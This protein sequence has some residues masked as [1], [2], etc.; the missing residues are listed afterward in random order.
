MIQLCTS[1][2]R[3]KYA[4]S[5]LFTVLFLILTSFELFSI[6]IIFTWF[7]IQNIQKVNSGVCLL[8]VLPARFLY[9]TASSGL[10]S[11]GT[12]FLLGE[13]G[14]PTESWALDPG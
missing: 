12:A 4:F 14:Y 8:S 2:N 6:C 10:T 7:K 11:Y 9:E 13:A 3:I 5:G 1:K